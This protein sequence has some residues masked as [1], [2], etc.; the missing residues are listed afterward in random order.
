M[1][2]EA[3]KFGLKKPGSC[4]V[5]A[6]PVFEQS[7]DQILEWL[8]TMGRGEPGKRTVARLIRAMDSAAGELERVRH[9][10]RHSNL[11]TFMRHAAKALESSEWNGARY[12]LMTA[13]ALMP[14]CGDGVSGTA[15][16]RQFPARNDA[17][18]TTV[19]GALMGIVT[20]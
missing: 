7:G 19:G 3:R 16:V 10:A 15:Q 18:A 6:F 9:S 14:A 2:A 11:A 20:G 5:I 12:L 13:Y 4:R 8:S 1:A 17:A